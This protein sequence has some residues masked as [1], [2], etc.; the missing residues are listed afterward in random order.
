MHTARCLRPAWWP[1]P[2]RAQTPGPGRARQQQ[3]LLIN[4]S[5]PHADTTGNTWFAAPPSPTS[6]LSFIT[7]DTP[8]RNP[9]S[10]DKQTHHWKPLSVLSSMHNTLLLLRGPA[11]PLGRQ[12]SPGAYVL[13]ALT[14]QPGVRCGRVR[15]APPPPRLR[16]RDSRVWLC[17]SHIPPAVACHRPAPCIPKPV[18]FLK[19]TRHSRPPRPTHPAPQSVPCRAPPLLQLR[20]GARSTQ[21]AAARAG[22]GCQPPPPLPAP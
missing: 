12:P 22:T 5:H 15:S 20:F 9:R 18:H 2:R 11:R 4:W 10:P 16:I 6:P 3:A 1:G 13:A 19:T 7:L 8:L 17:H 14:A 21:D